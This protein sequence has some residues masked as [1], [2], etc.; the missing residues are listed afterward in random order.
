[1]KIDDISTELPHAFP[2]VWQREKSFK[3]GF[4]WEFLRVLAMMMSE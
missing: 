2:V 4:S 3:D 1:M